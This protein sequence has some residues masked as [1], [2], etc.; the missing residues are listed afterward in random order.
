MISLFVD[1]VLTVNKQKP[2]VVESFVK[3]EGLKKGRLEE[4][5]DDVAE[6]DVAEDDV[7]TLLTVLLFPSKG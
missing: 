7:D 6:D 3:R 4:V 1:G 5:E 2:K